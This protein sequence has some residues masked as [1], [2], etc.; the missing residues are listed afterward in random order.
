M[1]NNPKNLTKLTLLTTIITLCLSL[2]IIT[3]CLPTGLLTSV[4]SN[5]GTSSSQS[6]NYSNSS[7]SNTTSPSANSFEM[8]VLN[9]T[10]VERTKQGL[11]PVT[12]NDKLA[13]AMDNH[14]KDMIANNYFDHISPSGS[15]PGDRATAAG[16]RWLKIGENIAKGQTTPKE[17]VN[18]WMNS[19]H[20]REN[21][22]NP[23][24]TELG[25][26][27]EYDAQGIPYWGQLF[28][29]PMP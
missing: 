4:T 7:A 15:T 28:G 12:W 23:D 16:Y 5:T 19:P 18:A 27:V 9:L 17:V 8:Q 13:T 14:C 6:S 22:L 10:N 1:K 21:I 11:N 2:A 24:F 20:H 29:T 3:G 25:V 26:A